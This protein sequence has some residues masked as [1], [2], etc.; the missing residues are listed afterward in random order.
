MNI[1]TLQSKLDFIKELYSNDEWTD[2]E[3]REDILAALEECHTNI[4]H[5]F[6]KSLCRLLDGE[7]KPSIEAVEKVVEKFPSALSYEDE[8]GCIPIAHISNCEQNYDA[9]GFEY[10]PTLAKE[11]VKH[12][13]GG[14]HGRGGVLSA[15]W[16][17]R[18][19][20][21]NICTFSENDIASLCVLKELRKMGLL[22]K[23][24]IQEYGLLSDQIVYLSGPIKERFEYL[25]DWDPDVLLN[26]DAFK[27]N[28]FD[29]DCGD[30]EPLL[31]AGFKHF[32][33]I[34]G[35]LFLRD[36]RG[37]T[38]LDL[39]FALDL[40]F[41][42]NGADGFQDIFYILHEILGPSSD[43]PI[44]HHVCT[45]APEHVHKFA[46][47]FWWAYHLKDHNN[48]TLHQAVLAAGPHVMNANSLLFASLTDDQLLTRDP[49][50][51]LYPFAAMAV[52]EH[53]K[54]GD[55]FDRLRRQPSVLERD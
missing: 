46:T 49:L 45:N 4:V 36:S 40:K 17:G 41:A 30:L 53:A 50:T 12:N 2:R 29:G 16:N 48:R 37:N 39:A 38:V 24:D 31:R 54:L 20:L 1:T 23:S 5:A 32:P 6:G 52:G 27:I 43:Y 42:R 55:I 22:V 26:I 34:G 44:L 15:C 51:T 11:G 21:Q 25:T 14:E 7:H 9:I 18:N 10:I 13:V 47:K 28:K 19:T 8:Y 35:I 33:N 3:C